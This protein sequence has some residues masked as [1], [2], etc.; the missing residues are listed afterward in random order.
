[1]CSSTLQGL[2]SASSALVA[3]YESERPLSA[4]ERAAL[5]ILVWGAAMRFF[6]TRLQDWGSTPEGALIKPHDPMDYVRKLDKHRAAY[7]SGDG[8]VLFGA[9]V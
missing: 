6:L 7:V 4:A 5:P 2:F 1:M 9:D 8:L 3:G